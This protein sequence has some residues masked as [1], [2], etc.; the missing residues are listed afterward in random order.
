MLPVTWLHPRLTAVQYVNTL[1]TSGFVDN[2]MFSRI[3]VNGQESDMAH[4]F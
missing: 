1:C 3:R 4:I 2:V